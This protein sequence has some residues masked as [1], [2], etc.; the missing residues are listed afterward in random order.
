MKNN[1]G[2]SIKDKNYWLEK[3]SGE[4]ERTR[5]SCGFKNI[6]QS[7]KDS[8]EGETGTTPI[9]FEPDLSSRL[10]QL[11]KG[12]N[13]MLYILLT[14]GLVHLLH[15]YSGSNDIII[16]TPIYK[17][18]IE[19]EFINSILV[20]RNR[21]EASMSFKELLLQVRQGIIEATEH[22]NFPLET[23]PQ[24][25]NLPITAGEFPLFDISILLDNI[26]DRKYIQ[27]IPTSVDFLFSRGEENLQGRIEYDASMFEAVIMEQ[28][29][30]HYVD[31]LNQVLV[32]VDARLEQTDVFSPGQKKWLLDELNDSHRDFPRGKTVWQ[33]FEEQVERTPQEEA[34]IA[35]GDNHHS[36]VTYRQLNA[37]ANQ[38][39][40]LLRQR[41]I[42][43]DEL[44][45]LMA[46]PSVEMAV[47]LWGIL[48]AGAAYLPMDA[49]YPVQRLRWL[50]LD[51]GIRYILFQE[52]ALDKEKVIPADLAAFLT[53]IN[54]DGAVLGGVEKPGENVADESLPPVSGPIHV[55]YIIYT[56]GSTGRPKGVMV[57]QR[58]LMNFACWRM[59][60]YK[61]GVSDTALQLFSFAFDG[62]AS[63]FYP[64]LLS[65]GKVLLPAWD[66]WKNNEYLRY[67]IREEKVTH[68]C[69]VPSMYRVLLDGAES[70]DFPLVRF[71]TLAGEKAS[72]ELVEISRKLFPRI[73]LVNEY[74]PTENSVGATVYWDMTP[75]EIAVI[76]KP[77][78][79]NR[80]LVLDSDLRLKPM[81]I[82]GE[83]CLSGESLA[84]G[85]LNRPELT[86]ETFIPHPFTPGERVYRTGDKARWLPQG[87]IELFG[88]FDNQEQIRG[89]RVEPGEIENVLVSHPDIKEAAVIPRDVSTTSSEKV[90]GG[91]KVLCAFI[92]SSRPVE[93][94]GI[95]S[96]LLEHVPEYMV[97]TYFI[98]L[99]S[100]PQTITGKVDRQALA[101][102]D[103]Q[104]HV[105]TEYT[106]PRTTMERRLAQI[107]EEFLEVEQVGI[108]DSFFNIGGD[109]IKSI[110]LLNIINK[111]FHANIQ[112]VDLYEYETVEKLASK[113]DSSRGLE[114][115]DLGYQEMVEDFSR[116]KERITGIMPP[117]RKEMLEDLFPMSDIQRGMLFYTLVDGSDSI[118]HNQIVQLFWDRSFSPERMARVFDFITQKHPMLRTGFSVQDYERPV[119]WVYKPGYV[120]IDY[121]HQDLTHL[122]PAAIPG[123]L[124]SEVEQDRSHPF[125]ISGGSPLWR[126]RTFDLGGGHICFSW[127]CHHA[128]IDGWSS[129]ALLTE[130]ATIYLELKHSPAFTPAPLANTYKEYVI[131]QELEK[132]KTDMVKFWKSQLEDYK[133]VVFPPLDSVLAGEGRTL[134]FRENLGIE[135]L[136]DLTNISRKYNTSI[137]H[138]CF[139]AYLYMLNMLSYEQDVLAGLVSHNRP[140]CED[141]EKMIGC[142]LNT[143]PVRLRIPETITYSGYFCLVEETLLQLK[144]YDA[145]SLFEIVRITGESNQAQNPLFDTFFNFVDF[146]V[147]RQLNM[148]D[149][150]NES[151]GQAYK[152]ANEILAMVDTVETNTA[153]DFTVDVTAGNFEFG[154]LYHNGFVAEAVVQA[155]ARWFTSI[156]DRFIRFPDQP[157]RKEELFTSGEKE[158][159]LQRFNNTGV[160]YSG[161][162]SIHE[163]F[164]RQYRLTPEASALILGESENNP[165]K[166]FSYQ[167]IE[168]KCSRLAWQLKQR[169]IGDETIVAV[170]IPPSLEMVV[171]ILAVLKAGGVY[172]PLVEEFPVQ[173]V[174]HILNDSKAA[175]ILTHSALVSHIP[176]GYQTLDLSESLLY[177]GENLKEGDSTGYLHRLAYV[178]YTS[179]S[180][181][182]PKGVMVEHHSVVN[183][184]NA[185]QQAYPFGEKDCY[186]L[187]TSFVFDV[188]VT[189]LFGWFMGGG[190]LAILEKGGEKDP[191]KI[192]AAIQQ[193]G[194]THIN[195]VPSMFNVFLDQINPDHLAAFSSLKYFFL[196]GEALSP[197]LV[198][199]FKQLNTSIRLENLYGPTEGTV[200]ASHYSLS[201]WNGETVPIGRPVNNCHLYI[202][203]KYGHIQPPGVIGELCIGGAGV[204]RGYANQPEMTGKQMIAHSFIEGERLYKTGDLARWLPDGNMEFLGRID[205]QVKIRGFRVELEE[206]EN[207]LVNHDR[208][209]EAIVLINQTVDG[210]AGND[211]DNSRLWA[212]IVFTPG[213]SAVDV[214]QLKEFLAR[215]LP[216][217]MIPSHFFRVEQIPLTVSGKVDRKALQVIGNKLESGVEFIA[218]VTAREKQIAAVWKEFLKIEQVGIHDKFFDIGG[219]SLDIINVTNRLRNVFSL[220]IPIVMMYRYPTIHAFSRYIEQQEQEGTPA[221]IEVDRT[222]EIEKGKRTRSVLKSRRKR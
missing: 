159:I 150:E 179:G 155:C 105:E 126:A 204:A 4:W 49:G 93:L 72:G 18:D 124:K 189:E 116:L 22:Q 38:M 200:Y 52:Q 190:R 139:A 151:T 9:T 114:E 137:K 195:F 213:E 206:I 132:K 71:V 111:E 217:Y 118:Y 80:V 142:F 95:R 201:A 41:G 146:H 209:K 165:L 39:A 11:S 62:F 160:E 64:C 205:L 55:A 37:R 141:G 172:L 216:A 171:G 34:V 153:F 176:G 147:Y 23:L 10:L 91:Y 44:V 6:N 85:Y 149:I 177:A 98:H 194:V 129:V 82:T 58:N 33:M 84:R 40:R 16:G 96:Y 5:I 79:N 24:Q 219:T 29:A 21:V 207:R 212:Y 50:I 211:K 182:K 26:H 65:G 113:I 74:G 25:L 178:M 51:S 97:P 158:I 163:L 144:K 89:F 169:G 123:Y 186:L 222:Q 35:R 120:A 143:V 48:K 191:G 173:R 112:L 30:G 104:P 168:E 67:L 193:F 117:E 31:L 122:E 215:D 199:K 208:I 157:V 170:L 45:G 8:D 99:N 90:S 77:I 180:T 59:T 32:R 87:D 68:F 174:R 166:I 3:L 14:A 69:V 107:W 214:T 81:G 127:S 145:L 76:G 83:L 183:L 46:V 181:G 210:L 17:Q 203:D 134:A 78:A 60:A 192:I 198:K 187:K 13:P 110:S 196:A 125:A 202:L 66:K 100:L 119:Q 220:D 175:L 92:V 47:G 88:R 156:L 138:L 102:F 108:K 2:H 42:G 12:S 20:L 73:R 54:L 57:E 184:L 197:Q 53:M 61:M 161:E 36:S 188:S 94:A 115:A 101:R 185:L 221:V 106:A 1:K 15:V 140:L 152:Y 19:G 130:I 131:R 28:V 128:I 63:N 135:R 75:G 43:P 154:I 103:I 27:Y 162:Q 7:E 167:D 164:A 133:R 218:P 70:R 121:I 148:E 56:S 136:R 86:A 109:S